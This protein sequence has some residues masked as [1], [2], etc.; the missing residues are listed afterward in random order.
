MLFR[1]DS[2]RPGMVWA[3]SVARG[4]AGGRQ[5]KRSA[6]VS[7]WVR[8][9]LSSATFLLDI[10][11]G[12]INLDESGRSSTE[13]VEI[14]LLLDTEMERLEAWVVLVDGVSHDDASCAGG[15]VGCILAV[16]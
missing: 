2:L 14:E 12:K 3:Y 1:D 6:Q 8:L 4:V 10:L 13:A 7:P 16:S 9:Q 5:S 11:L 15:V